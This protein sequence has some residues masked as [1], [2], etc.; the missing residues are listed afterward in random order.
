MILHEIILHFYVSGLSR[1][2]WIVYR[3][4]LLWDYIH[5]DDGYVVVHTMFQKCLLQL[6]LKAEVHPLMYTI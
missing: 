3:N 1:Q 2:L 6:T 5:F 4:Q